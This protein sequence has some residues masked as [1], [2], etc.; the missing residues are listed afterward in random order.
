MIACK[1]CDQTINGNY[2]SHCGMPAQVKRVDSHYVLHE[3]QHLLHLE[4]GIFYTIRKLLFQPGQSIHEFITANRSRLVKPVLFII[5][6]SVI[7]TFLSHILHTA[8]EHGS[9]NPYGDTLV[10]VWIQN[11]YGYANIIMGVFIAFWL[12]LFF[13]KHNYNFFELLILLCFVMGMG[14]FFC[15]LSLLLQKLIQTDIHNMATAISVAYC[16][17]GIGQFFNKN[18]VASYLKALAAY[19][20]GMIVFSVSAIILGTLIEL[21]RHH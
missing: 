7:Y 10:S 5:I 6:T 13:R 16:V 11:Y 21:I 4:K 3:I 20:L 14:M 15:S 12:K 19:L 17:W 8:G 1:S 9:I 2:C 18:K